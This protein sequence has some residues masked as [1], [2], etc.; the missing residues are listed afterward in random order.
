MKSSR[1]WRSVFALSAL[2]LLVLSGIEFEQ[3]VEDLQKG[4]L[5]VAT[6]RIR[7]GIFFQSVVLLVNHSRFGA[8]GLIVSAPDQ[9]AA[10][11]KNL[12]IGGPVQIQSYRAQLS[13][14]REECSRGDQIVKGVCFSEYGEEESS[15]AL[16]ETTEEDLMGQS[17]LRNFWGYAGWAPWQLEAEIRSG[18]WQV[19]PGSQ[20]LVFGSADHL[21][22]QLN[23]RH[24][25][26]RCSDRQS[27]PCSD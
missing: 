3:E 24:E 16:E 9:S 27:S 20:D 26:E 10:K 7:S 15:Q 13:W 5:L 8:K 1:P 11:S 23:Q 25:S 6:D 21:W 2:L 22:Q 19:M 12:H 17:N 14:S 4:S 18:A